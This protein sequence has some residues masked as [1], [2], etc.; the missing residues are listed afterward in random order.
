M[1]GLTG[2]KSIAIHIDHRFGGAGSK[3]AVELNKITFDVEM[4]TVEE[5]RKCPGAGI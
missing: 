3:N 5:E 4:E 1:A 2:K